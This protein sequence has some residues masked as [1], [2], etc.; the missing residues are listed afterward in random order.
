MIKFLAVGD[1][2]QAQVRATWSAA[3][4]SRRVVP[5]VED[6]IEDAWQR[7]LR[8]PN[9]HVFD[10]PMCRMDAFEATPERLSV[11]LSETSYKV[12]VGTNMWHPQFADQYGTDV[13]ANPVGLSTI[14]ETADG[15]LL[16]GRRNAA[17]VYYAS[18]V[19]P[20]AGTLEPKDAGNAFAGAYRE[21]NE[22]LQLA[23]ADVPDLRCTGV[24]EDASLLHPEL[25][26]AARSVRTLSQIEASLDRTE[27]D[28]VFSFAADERGVEPVLANEVLTPVAVASVLLWGRLRFGASWF[29]SRSSAFVS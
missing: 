25:I 20:F 29:E 28:S 13:M 19:H 10:G 17:V 16:L 11:T 26:F 12:F 21:L 5:D 2:G 4:S 1:W 9:V 8:R 15:R 24:V 27:H 22:E 14:L 6:A 3:S 23:E 18:R 7:T